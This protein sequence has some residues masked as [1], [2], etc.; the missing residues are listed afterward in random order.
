MYN[1]SVLCVTRT[2]AAATPQ[3]STALW[4]WGTQFH[5]SVIC[6]SVTFPQLL[7]LGL[8]NAQAYLFAFDF[9]KKQTLLASHF[10]L[11]T[12]FFQFT[13]YHLSSSFIYF[14]VSFQDHFCLLHCISRLT[15]VPRIH[16]SLMLS[17]YTAFYL[18]QPAPFHSLLCKTQLYI[19][20]LL[21]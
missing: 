7:L 13:H 16:C 2:A 1:S 11:A 12:I 9:L 18:R 17:T 20:I 10:S 14:F 6:S 15:A 4:Y 5:S 21:Q 3:L 19:N 8:T